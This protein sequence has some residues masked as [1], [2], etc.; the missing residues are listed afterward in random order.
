LLAVLAVVMSLG[1]FWLD[2]DVGLD[3]AGEGNLWYGSQAVSR[4][5]VPIRDFQ[6]DDA[7]RYL[8]TAGW[9]RVLGQDLVSLRLSCV[10]FQCLG[11]TAGLLVAWRLSRNWL[12]LLSVALL[13]SAWMHPR[14]Q[15]FEQNIALMSVYAGLLLLEKPSV[16]RHFGVGLF[17][18]LMAFL[19]RNHGVYH[20]VAFLLVILLAARGPGFRA[21]LQGSLAWT[22]GLLLGYL[23]QLLMFK[24]VPGYLGEFKLS[25]AALGTKGPG[26]FSAVPWPWLVDMNLPKWR[27]A[28]A[29][30]EGAFFL[31]LP[32]FLALVLVRIFRLD[33][34]QLVRHGVL[35]AAACVT[36]PYTHLAFSRPDSAH[37]S[38][39]AP[40]LVLGLLAFAFASAEKQPW[41]WKASAL[42]LLAASLLTNFFETGL[43][44]KIFPPPG[45]LV[46]T[47]VRGRTMRIG[48]DEAQFLASATK[49]TTEAAN[50]DEPIL[51]LPN[52]ST[53]YPFTSRRSP[54]RKLDFTAPPSLAEQTQIIREIE[55]G[56]VQWTM[57][58][59]DA[60]GGREDLRFRNT[61]PL[62]FAHL[63]RYFAPFSM[64]DLPPDT[65]ILRRKALQRR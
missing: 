51:F 56:R 6:S 35:V 16:N 10:I 64:E 50:E 5:E 55:E 40:T 34:E 11:I 46:R 33:R 27:W 22:V 13:L 38:H 32:V 61:S 43:A 9:S 12:F 25:V 62:I 1:W 54:I 63:G 58:R 8:W 3:L 29:V 59:D 45:G 28:A 65:V 48:P 42:V 49:L 31:G 17:G 53:L 18:G 14:F 39:V 26:L 57:L 36:L 20:L 19:G 60:V 2:G 24:V 37:L 30:L 41:L 52:L 7:G 44:Q 4:G 47:Q 15:S 23:P 21:W